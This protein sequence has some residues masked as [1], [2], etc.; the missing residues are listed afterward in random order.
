MILTF[1]LIGIFG[2]I[3]LGIATIVFA[4]IGGVKANNGELWE[5]PG[6]IVK[7]FK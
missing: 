1:V 5:Y 3:A 6:T 4:V 2:F 7:V